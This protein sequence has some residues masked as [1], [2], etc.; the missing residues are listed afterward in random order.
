MRFRPQRQFPQRI[1][2][3]DGEAP[4]IVRLGEVRSPWQDLYHQLLRLS[5]PAF[6]V[7]LALSYLAINTLFALA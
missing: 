2:T 1:V 6:V 4:A 7:V 3:R 5:W